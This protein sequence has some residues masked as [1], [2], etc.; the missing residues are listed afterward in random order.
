MVGF[1]RD[2]PDDFATFWRKLHRR[3]RELAEVFAVSPVALYLR[4]QHRLAGHFARFE[5]DKPVY[6]KHAWR[7]GA[8][9]NAYGS[10]LSLVELARNG[11]TRGAGSLVWNGSTVVRG[12][13]VVET[14]GQWAGMRLHRTNAS[15][16]W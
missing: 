15:G 8:R 11:S 7:G 10:R 14:H 16:N 13:S 4:A 9:N 6:Q 1:K 12:W 2:P 5:N 3:E